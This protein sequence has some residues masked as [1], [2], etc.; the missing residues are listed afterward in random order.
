MVK[1]GSAKDKSRLGAP[2]AELHFYAS[3]QLEEALAIL[4]DLAQPPLA[5]TLTEIDSDHFRFELS[6]TLLPGLPMNAPPLV[7]GT[8]R[9]WEG[10]YT[11]L[12]AT[13]QVYRFTR[14]PRVQRTR[15]PMWLAPLVMLAFLVAAAQYQ[16]AASLAVA[17]FVIVAGLSALLTSNNSAQPSAMLAGWEDNPED[18]VEFRRRDELFRQIIAAFKARGEVAWDSAA[19]SDRVDE[20]EADLFSALRASEDPAIREFYARINGQPRR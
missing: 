4:A 7:Y 2:S 12:D 3:V 16:D 13:G 1:I 15:G 20:A 14:N 6:Y 10:T 18:V 5:V 19:L 11:R 9:R 17:A 8:L